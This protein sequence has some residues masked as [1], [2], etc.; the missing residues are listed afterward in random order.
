MYQGMISW[1]RR[2]LWNISRLS[3]P[4]SKLLRKKAKM[5]WETEQEEA[6]QE[7]KKRVSE[8]PVLA[9]PDWTKQF[10]LQTIASKNGLGVVAV[11]QEQ[12]GENES[13]PMPAES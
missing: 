10:V 4:I 9:S 12:Y 1:M 3:D 6:F 5:E 7:I 13:S 2:L 8:A 11:T